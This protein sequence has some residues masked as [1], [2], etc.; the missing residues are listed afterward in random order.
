[1]VA[2]SQPAIPLQ[3]EVR[4]LSEAALL[5]PAVLDAGGRERRSEGRTAVD[6]TLWLVDHAGHTILPCAALDASDNGMRLRVPIGYGIGE[7]QQ[8]ELRAQPSGHPPPGASGLC[9]RRWATIVRTKLHMD[10]S[11]AH[12]EVGVRLGSRQTLELLA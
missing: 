12:I 10:H 9:G 3:A 4:S 1:M 5:T 7:G 6:C 11:N 2:P 8:Y